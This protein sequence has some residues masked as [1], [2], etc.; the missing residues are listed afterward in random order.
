M[1][2]EQAEPGQAAY[3]AA[4][5]LFADVLFTDDA[6][7]WGELGVA[8]RE[9]WDRVAQAAIAAA[10]QPAPELA[11]LRQ[12]LDNV[13]AVLDRQTLTYAER[14]SYARTLIRTARGARPAGLPS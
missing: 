8:E 14:I 5:V 13:F 1:S 10:P 9:T 4:R 6:V 2:R 3:E 11:A 12:A 7:P